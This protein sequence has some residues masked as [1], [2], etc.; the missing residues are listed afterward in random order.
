M[1][2]RDGDRHQKIQVGDTEVKQRGKRFPEEASTLATG[3]RPR[4]HGLRYVGRST[5]RISADPW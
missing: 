4:Q 5:K 2:V 1:A 3:S